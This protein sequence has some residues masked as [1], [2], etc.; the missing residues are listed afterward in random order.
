M[1]IPVLF[2]IFNRPETEAVVF[3]RIHEYRPDRLYVAADGPRDNKPGEK[4]LCEA[5]RDIV[6]HVDWPCE[7]R[8][9]FQ[10]SNLGCGLGV[11]TAINWFFNNEEYG[12][13]VEDDVLPSLDFFRFCETALPR[14]KEEDKV[15]LIS[16]FVPE[17][18]NTESS[19]CG[20][21]RYANIWGW[22]SWKRA[23][24]HFDLEMQQ[25]RSAP[26]MAW[27][28]FYGLFLGIYLHYCCK[29]LYASYL[30]TGKWHTWD[31][32][33]TFTLF[34]E[35]GF[36]LVPYVNL[37]RNVGIGVGDGTHFEPDASDPFGKATIGRMT[38]PYQFP[39][40]LK[41]D[42]TIESWTFKQIT[43]ARIAGIHTRMK[44]LFRFKYNG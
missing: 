28:R 33:W 23:W 9:L 41:T 39:P 29:K 37:T 24:S 22:A 8:T 44:R 21:S 26:I 42:R 17:S 16:S 19:G 31:Y 30:E 6:R 1:K 35:N 2:I 10:D 20:F 40:A 36:S 27:I 4:E 18:R 7:V 38:S 14:Y 12:C 13:I 32:Q 43:K 15:M 25:A 34:V 5:A 11:S 3:N